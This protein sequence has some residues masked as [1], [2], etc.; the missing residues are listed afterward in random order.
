[1]QASITRNTLGW[2]KTPRLVEFNCSFLENRQARK[3]FLWDYL[4]ILCWRYLRFSLG[5]EFQDTCIHINI[6]KHK[7]TIP[8]ITFFIP[9][10]HPFPSLSFPF[11]FIHSITLQ[12]LYVFLLLSHFATSIPHVLD[13]LSLLLLHLLPSALVQ[14]LSPRSHI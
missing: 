14:N 3:H 6:T 5:T 7:I 4:F 2:L 8:K 10:P 1:M 12:S 11:S 9:I 13:C